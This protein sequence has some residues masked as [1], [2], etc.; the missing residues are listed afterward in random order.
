MFVITRV[1]VIRR[2]VLPGI[3]SGGIKREI[4]LTMTMIKVGMNVSIKYGVILRLRSIRIVIPSIG[5]ITLS[6][7]PSFVSFTSYC[8]SL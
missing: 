6:F 1:R 3:M 8:S 7:G 4:Q 5:F 2:P